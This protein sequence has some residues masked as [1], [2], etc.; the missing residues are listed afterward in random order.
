ME[1]VL[2][3]GAGASGLMAANILA[4]NNFKVT[5]VEARDRTGGRIHTIHSLFSLPIEAGAEFMHGKQAIT[6]SLLEKFGIATSV[7]SG[8]WYQVRNGQRQEGDFFDKD[9]ERL[10]KALKKLKKDTDIGSFLETHFNKPA[11]RELVEKVRGFVEG[12]DAADMDRASAIALRDEWSGNDEEHQYHI[13]GGYGRLIQSLEDRLTTLGG[14]VLL[15]TTVKEIQWKKG[16]STVIT[17]T[18][19]SFTAP[20]IIVTVPLGVLQ[21]GGITFTPALPEYFEAFSVMG[22]GGVIKFFAEFEDAFWT[23]RV[24][25]TLPDLAFVISDGEIPTWWTHRP[26]RNPVL[27]GWLGGP[28]TQSVECDPALLRDKAVRSLAYI[29][30]CKAE[31][32]ESGIKRWHIENWVKDPLARGAYAYP[33]IDT[34]SALDVVTRPVDGTIY[35]AGEGMYR[36][37]AIGTVEAALVSG[38]D[39]AEQMIGSLDH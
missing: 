30:Q 33:T 19:S 22:F 16:Q 4:E 14:S 35:F 36:G 26:H 17:T 24:H 29:F 39:V 9:W 20:K 11:D 25:R 23:D 3:I 28:S 8:N 12:Y 38:K 37:S 31:E 2:I 32:L 34:E 5:V 10:T 6:S 7:L 21:H 18:G 1:Q 13:E 27:T 15:S